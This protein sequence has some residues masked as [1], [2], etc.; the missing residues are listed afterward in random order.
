MR[1]GGDVPGL[2]SRRVPG[3][4]HVNTAKK[5]TKNHGGKRVKLEYN[6][7]LDEATMHVD[8]KSL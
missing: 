3:Q 7:A 5:T 4:Q 8:L 6:L 1:Q 2:A